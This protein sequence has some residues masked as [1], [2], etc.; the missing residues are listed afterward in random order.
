MKRLTMALASACAALLGAVMLVALGQQATAATLT[1]VTGFGANPGNLRMHLYVPDNVRA[2]PAIILAMHGCGGNGPGFYSGSEFASLA[3]QYGFIVIYPSASKKGNCFDSWSAEAKRR[4]GGSD[5]VSLMSMITYTQQRYNGDIGRI[6]V[7]GSSAGGMETNIMLGNYPDVFKAGAV[8]MGVPHSCFASEADYIPSPGASD[9]AS[10]RLNKTPQQWGDLARAAYPGYSGTRPRV[11]LWHGTADN[12]V[13]YATLQQQIDQWTN[14]FGLSQTPTSTDTPRANWNRRRY[15]D[16]AGSV[17]VEAYSIQ[18]A[19]HSLPMS[20]MAA[21]AI[22][23]FGLTANDPGPSPTQTPTSPPPGAACQVAYTANTWNNGFTAEVAITNSGNSTING[24]TLTWTWPG[25]QQV[26]N[27]WNATVTQSGSQVT[28]RN[29]A[30][31]GTI[32]AG[33]RGSFGFQAT[34]SGTNTAPATFALNGSPC[35]AL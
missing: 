5:P 21:S 28:A 25:N 4:N 10:G 27:A 18:G 3:N 30:H 2:Q 11:Q 6:F 29:A 34:Y 22:E 7:T 13:Y 15:A 33:T 9:C 1:E 12:L 24:W 17:K 20:G 31:N 26:T 16:A 32:A 35:S 14:V 19:G 23:F 8:F